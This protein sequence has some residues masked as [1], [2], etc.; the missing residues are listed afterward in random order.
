[1]IALGIVVEAILAVVLLRTGRGAVIG[2]MVAVA[3]LVLLGLVFE[4]IIVTPQE[5]VEQTLD[6]VASALEADSL[7]RVLDYLAPDAPQLRSLAETNMPDLHFSEAKIRDLKTSVNRFVDPPTAT[8]EFLGV[9][10]VKDS[11]GQF[12]YEHYLD[13]FTVHLRRE[14]NRWLLTSYERHASAE[15][16]PWQTHTARSH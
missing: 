3:G 7:P 15:S 4:R 6:G 8:A 11:R 2:L 16:P 14:G 10:S 5:E 1:M 13:R 12:P 9:L